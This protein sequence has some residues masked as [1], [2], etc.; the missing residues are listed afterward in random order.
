MSY[1]VVIQN[2][3]IDLPTQAIN[4]LLELNNI[5]EDH[6]DLDDFNASD[7]DLLTELSGSLY[8]WKNSK[9]LHILG[10]FTLF[11]RIL[12]RGMCWPPLFKSP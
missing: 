7:A 8:T 10:S 2:K 4:E 12:N 9:G 3:F 1:M 6:F 11:Y 5:G